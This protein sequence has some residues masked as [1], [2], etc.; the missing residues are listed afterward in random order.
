MRAVQGKR[1][2]DGL[3]PVD[4]ITLLIETNPDG[5]SA[6]ESHTDMIQNT[7]GATGIE[8]GSNLGEKVTAGEFTFIFSFEK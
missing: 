2:T 4:T 3:K 1:K 7:V 6:I 8:F 5:Q